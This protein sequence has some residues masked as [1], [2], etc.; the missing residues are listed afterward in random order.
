M[1]ILQPARLVLSEQYFFR[2][3]IL[4]FITFCYTDGR[5]F[6]ERVMSLFG[7]SQWHVRWPAFRFLLVL[8]NASEAGAR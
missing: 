6:L 5:S 7:C 4:L 1:I 3:P 8:R 2:T